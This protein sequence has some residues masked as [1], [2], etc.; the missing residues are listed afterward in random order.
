MFSNV[1]GGLYADTAKKG[2][3]NL[4]KG[5]SKSLLLTLFCLQIKECVWQ[6][7]ELNINR[8]VV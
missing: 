5:D 7:G 6:E 4:A 3:M 8:I 1:G 2:F